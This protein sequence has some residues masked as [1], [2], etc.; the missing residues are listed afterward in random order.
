MSADD[1]STWFIANPADPEFWV[2]GQKK[3]VT[4]ILTPITVPNVPCD[5]SIIGA[6]NSE[7]VGVDLRN[8][9]ILGA[10]VNYQSFHGYMDEISIYDQALSSDAIS[11]IYPQSHTSPGHNGPPNDIL[12]ANSELLKHCAIWYRSGDGGGIVHTSYA[13]DKIDG[14]GTGAK[15]TAPGG[16]FTRDA[17]IATNI[18]YD[19]TSLYG[20][21]HAIPAGTAQ[22]VTSVS[23]TFIDV[24]RTQ[25]D[26]TIQLPGAQYEQE[27]VCSYASSS[28]YDNWYVTHEIPRSESQYTW[29]SSSIQRDPF[30]TPMDGNGYG[31]WGHPN[32]EG[33][34]Q[35]AS[36][37]VE[38]PTYVEALRFVSSSTVGSVEVSTSPYARYFG[39]SWEEASGYS[40]IN[41]QPTDFVRLNTNVFEPFS[42]S[43]NT[44]GYPLST[45]AYDYKNAYMIDTWHPGP[46]TTSPYTKAEATLLHQ[47]IHHRQGPYGWPSWKQIRGYEHPIRVSEI[48]NSR[49]TIVSQPEEKLILIPYETDAGATK[50]FSKR[51]KNISH[52]P[53]TT[54]Y[55][56]PAIVNNCPMTHV[57]NERTTLVHPYRNTFCMYSNQAINNQMGIEQNRPTMYSALVEQ[58]SKA[59]SSVTF[60]YLS[61]REPIYPKETN[62]YRQAIRRR[63]KFARF[64]GFWSK[65][66]E[67]RRPTILHESGFDTALDSRCGVDEAFDDLTCTIDNLYRNSQGMPIAGNSDSLDLL[68]YP[69]RWILDAS[70]DILTKTY[71]YTNNWP[72]VESRTEVARLTA[73]K[74]SISN[75][76]G[77][78]MGYHCQLRGHVKQLAAPFTS[79]YDSLVP[80]AQYA[81]RHTIA[82]SSSA[83]SLSGHISGSLKFGSLA[84]NNASYRYFV[85]L[86][87]STDPEGP[88][89]VFGGETMFETALQSGKYPSYDSYE[90]YSQL[91]IWLKG[92]DYSI[93]PEFRISEHMDYYI[94][95]MGGNFLADN[96]GSLTLLGA[97]VNSSQQEDFYATYSHSDFMKQFDIVDKDHAFT[98]GP[99]SIELKCKGILKLLPYEGF[100]PAQRTA[101]LASLFS[102]S[103]GSQ[104]DLIQGSG[105]SS[106]NYGYSDGPGTS[107]DVRE[108]AALWSVYLRPFF[109]PGIMFNTIKSGIAV[110]YPI[111]TG[112]YKIA[113]DPLTTVL[114]Q[115]TWGRTAFGTKNTN[116]GYQ[117]TEPAFHDRV[118][119]EA[120][121][122][123]EKYI[124]DLPVTNMEPH[125]SGSYLL[126]LTGALKSAGDS[127]YRMAANNFFA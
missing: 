36:S 110:D 58:Y 94:T 12:Q 47:L 61:Y 112:D 31:A 82:P 90:D 84:V 63:Q 89:Q 64:E 72:I 101:Q 40:F 87:S 27:T 55:N 57:I 123:P 99:S 50:F 107:A 111:M 93:V 26:T 91:D 68:I 14:S 23:T 30:G 75:N 86:G 17:E 3:A 73:T 33:L 7:A 71:S 56:E 65:S 79:R 115:D 49:L 13:A 117:I 46:S 116:T 126:S 59:D 22:G 5:R 114:S 24:S 92:K 76:P 95:R 20:K 39:G 80:H 53:Y 103:Y 38:N 113:K 74:Q 105:Y 96:T 121:I 28:F 45:D 25:S 15:K 124:I 29:I 48:R 16:G 97:T 35:A 41:F 32:A 70:N 10:A 125:P 67:D 19:V 88:I 83:D 51:I 119:F 44:L 11:A 104:I 34:V 21:T 52:G 127:R 66:R 62:R 106:N 8:M 43:S 120:I 6:A 54:A 69:S 42:A 77:E 60:N 4:R 18:I 98:G 118:P 78:L 102:Q 85:D 1:P 109:A 100:Y 37:S 122:E 108:Q 81:R 2:N 9:N